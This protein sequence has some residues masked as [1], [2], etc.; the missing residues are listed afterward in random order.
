VTAREGP[1]DESAALFAAVEVIANTRH[2]PGLD[3]WF[4]L[5]ERGLCDALAK[6]GPRCPR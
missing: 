4:D 1:F 6:L 5:A 2:P 3:W